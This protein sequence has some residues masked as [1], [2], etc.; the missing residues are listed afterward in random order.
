MKGTPNRKIIAVSALSALMHGAAQGV[1]NIFSLNESG[2][3]IDLP[4]ITSINHGYHQSRTT[5][6]TRQRKRRHRE[7][8]LRGGG[9]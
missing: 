4:M 1:S 6:G 8:Q 9:K 3:D 7:R 5:S 2:R